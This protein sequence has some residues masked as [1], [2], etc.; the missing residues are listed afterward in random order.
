MLAKQWISEYVEGLGNDASHLSKRRLVQEARLR[1][2]RFAGLRRWYVPEIIGALPILL[3][4]ALLLFGVGLIDFFWKLDNGTSIII[5]VFISIIYCL[6]VTSVA[7]PSFFPDSP[8]R[9]P[10][11]HL[12]SNLM[13]TVAALFNPSMRKDD[14]E[15]DPSNLN[16][17]ARN[18]LRHGF[19]ANGALLEA[20]RSEV[21]KEGRELDRQFLLRLKGTARSDTL[22]D[23]ADLELETLDANEANRRNGGQD[24]PIPNTGG[25]GLQIGSTSP[26]EP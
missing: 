17:L 6:Y 8:Y 16:Y 12:L 2:F 18:K 14:Y 24:V 9:T 15:Q 1:E 4:V 13:R 5:L 26:K 11:S 7:L 10:L 3:H 20:E 23:W 19:T 22:A 25:L 21:E